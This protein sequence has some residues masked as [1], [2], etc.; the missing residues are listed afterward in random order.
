[1]E[2]IVKMIEIVPGIVVFPMFLYFIVILFLLR[3]FF[4]S[5]NIAKIILGDLLW[6]ISFF[7]IITLFFVYQI[8]LSEPP[9]EILLMLYYTLVP[10][11]IIIN[12][13]FLFLQGLLTRS[14]SNQNDKQKMLKQKKRC[15]LAHLL[16]N[17]YLIFSEWILFIIAF[18]VVSY[19]LYGYL[20]RK[21]I[22]CQG[23]HAAPPK[24][25]KKIIV[26]R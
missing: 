20:F 11:H 17:F 15:F 19:L 2:N 5:K 4:S 7:L 13:V 22:E 24:Q 8:E 6:G 9:G 25:E 12:G 1:M 18:G 14:T 23:I 10:F 21:I 26:I 16:F 3:S